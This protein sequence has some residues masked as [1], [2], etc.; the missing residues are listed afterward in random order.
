VVHVDAGADRLALG[1]QGAGSDAQ[2]LGPVAPA[3]G[4]EH[5]EVGRDHAAVALVHEGGDRVLLGGAV[6]GG[7][8]AHVGDQHHVHARVEQGGQGEPRRDV[9]HGQAAVSVAVLA[10]QHRA[11]GQAGVLVPVAPAGQGA[12][13]QVAAGWSDVHGSFGGGAARLAVFGLDQAGPLGG[14]QRVDRGYGVVG[15]GRGQRS[16]GAHEPVRVDHPV[17]GPA[18]DVGER[19]S[20]VVGRLGLHLAHQVVD[21]GHR[22]LGPNAGHWRTG[23]GVLHDHLGGGGLAVHLAVAGRAGALHYLPLLEGRGLKGVADCRR[24]AVDRPG[25]LHLDH[26]V[27]RV[28]GAARRAGQR[29][30]GAGL[31]GGDLDRGQR[32]RRVQDGDL[33]GDGSHLVLAVAR[34]HAGLPHLPL[35]RAVCGHGG[36]VDVDRGPVDGPGQRVLHRITVRIAGLVQ[37]QHQV[38]GGGGLGRSQAQAGLGGWVV[39]AGGEQGQQTEQRGGPHE[40]SGSGVNSTTMGM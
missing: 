35:G 27:V 19:V 17:G 22:S 33:G 29:I 9:D 3:V 38:V 16:L 14:Q 32:G 24:H 28:A 30:A 34:G 11:P 20:V 15:P 12:H 2:Q 21:P 26:V 31:R 37:G 1:D 39:A 4:F 5:H 8:P 6:G 23:R 40:S 13:D 36:A 18:D 7:A 25:E 10:G